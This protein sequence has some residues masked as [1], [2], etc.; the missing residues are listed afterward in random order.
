MH[1]MGEIHYFISCWYS[2]NRW[3]AALS[4]ERPVFESWR[5]ES[6]N[7]FFNLKDVI[8]HHPPDV[9]DVYNSNSFQFLT[10]HRVSTTD[11]IVVIWARTPRCKPQLFTSLNWVVQPRAH[12]LWCAARQ[13]SMPVYLP[14][15][16]L[17]VDGRSSNDKRSHSWWCMSS[18]TYVVLARAC[19]SNFWSWR[20]T[21]TKTTNGRCVSEWGT[22]LW[23]WRRCVCTATHYWSGKEE[24]DRKCITEAQML[25]EALTDNVVGVVRCTVGAARCG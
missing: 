3:G 13:T 9:V 10:V 2:L 18:H 5:S 21:K 1:V 11:F 8:A 20:T 12:W 25:P 17:G 15:Y 4:F 19:L 7:F 16:I 14:T 24:C 22:G 23:W 6:S